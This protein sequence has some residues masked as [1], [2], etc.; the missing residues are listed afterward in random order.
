MKRNENRYNGTMP[1]CPDERR[2][3]YLGITRKARVGELRASSQGQIANVGD[4]LGLLFICSSQTTSRRLLVTRNKFIV[5]GCVRLFAFIALGEVRADEE[6]K[7]LSL[8]ITSARYANSF[9][10]TCRSSLLRSQVR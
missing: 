1:M 7:E 2:F 10:S 5:F 8:R 9:P 6:D 4:I 3:V